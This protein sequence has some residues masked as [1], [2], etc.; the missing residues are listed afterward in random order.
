MTSRIPGSSKQKSSSVL[1]PPSTTKLRDVAV[2]AAHAG[3]RVLMKRF[4]TRLRVN[5]KPGEG[6]VTN[7]D[8]ESERAALSILKRA[9]PD[10]GVLTEESSGKQGRSPGRWIVD[11]LDGTTNYA[12]GF[13]TFCVSIA[14]EWNGEVLVGVIHHPILHETYTAIRGKGAFV[15]GKRMQVSKTSNLREAMLTTGFSSRKEKWLGQEILAFRRLSRAAHAVRRP[16]SSALDL[17]QVA[18]GV[19]DG[20]WERGLSPWDVAAGAL[21]VREAGGLVT[22]FKGGPLRLDSGELLCSNG[23]IHRALLREAGLRSQPNPR[24]RAMGSRTRRRT[25]LERASV[26][27]SRY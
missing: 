13:P 18:R 19:F 1:V 11:P 22:D 26:M 12:H 27:H 14:A 9:F 17:A 24:V 7:A 23:V 10:F 25:A 8:F 15:N 16:G 21:M 2:Q 3:G 20:F 6:L 5:E 4:R